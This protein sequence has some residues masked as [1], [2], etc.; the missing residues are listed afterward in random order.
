MTA[1]RRIVC[2]VTCGLLAIALVS[3]HP[4]RAERRALNGEC[5]WQD[6]KAVAW[7]DQQVQQ[8]SIPP[9]LLA[10]A[11]LR[12]LQARNTCMHGRVAVALEAYEAAFRFAAPTLSGR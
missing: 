9:V 1:S 10:E 3:H 4:A 12:V 2:L 11:A 7:I 6:A 5:A 8:R